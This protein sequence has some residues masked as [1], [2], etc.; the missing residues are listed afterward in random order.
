M[1]DEKMC[2]SV[3]KNDIIVR[4]WQDNYDQALKQKWTK[5]MKFAGEPLRWFILVEPEWFSSDKNLENRV[6]LCLESKLKQ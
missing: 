4:V 3:T 1:V 6:Q 5:V 2:I